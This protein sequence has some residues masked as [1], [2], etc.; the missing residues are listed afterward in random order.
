M[1]RGRHLHLEYK[2]RTYA[3]PTSNPLTELTCA[4]AIGYPSMG[5][6]LLNN[7]ACSS[8][9]RIYG[10]GAERPRGAHEMKAE[11]LPYCMGAGTLQ[12]LH[13]RWISNPPDKIMLEAWHTAWDRHP[14]GPPWQMVSNRP[15]KNIART[16]ARCRY[17]RAASIMLPTGTT[18]NK[19]KRAEC[20]AVFIV[21]LR[22]HRFTRFP[23]K[24]PHLALPPYATKVWCIC[25]LFVNFT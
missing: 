21:F 7:Q 1:A 22:V 2:P 23:T 24:S 4:A 25:A 8:R 12:G 16:H 10:S 18:Q 17:V 11:G 6:R 3:Q 14:T 9:K 19:H 15:T 5:R 13:C 20:P